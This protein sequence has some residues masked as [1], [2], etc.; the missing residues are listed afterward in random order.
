MNYVMRAK[1]YFESLVSPE[2]QTLETGANTEKI[3]E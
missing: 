2:K 1:T 3:C